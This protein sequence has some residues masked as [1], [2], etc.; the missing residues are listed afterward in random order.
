MRQ[1]AARRLN[2]RSAQNHEPASRANT[3]SGSR[4]HGLGQS[5]LLSSHLYESVSSQSSSG[6]GS[7]WLV[8]L[9]P[10]RQSG[11]CWYIIKFLERFPMHQDL[12]R[13]F[14]L[15]CAF[16][17]MA[18]RRFFWWPK[19]TVTPTETPAEPPT[20]TAEPPKPPAEAVTPFFPS[21]TLYNLLW[22]C[23]REGVCRVHESRARG[24]LCVGASS[25]HDDTTDSG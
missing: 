22:L 10:H 13:S 20:L 15:F 16:R 18:L 5:S 11:D 1:R 6:D 9:P 12:W 7:C 14:S 3:C 8:F 21:Y 17:R 19:P 23:P 25:N 24:V 4:V 2:P